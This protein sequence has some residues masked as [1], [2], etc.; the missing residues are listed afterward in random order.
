MTPAQINQRAIDQAQVVTGAYRRGLEQATGQAAP[1]GNQADNQGGN[2]RATPNTRA[3]GSDAP[4][5]RP[6][7]PVLTQND[8]SDVPKDRVDE[9]RSIVAEIA[10]TREDVNR[11][12][13][14]VGN[15]MSDSQ[16]T[17]AEGMRNILQGAAQGNRTL[18]NREATD[19]AN[20][21]RQL[22]AQN[23][24][25]ARLM[26]LAPTTEQAS[27]TASAE[28]KRKLLPAI[29]DEA[30]RLYNQ[31]STLE[32][33]VRPIGGGTERAQATSVVGQMYDILHQAHTEERP[34]TR[35]ETTRYLHFWSRLRHIGP[36]YSGWADRL[37][38]HQPVR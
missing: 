32:R 19:Y 9:L 6:L 1:T 20:L 21:Q 17:L 16:R 38:L 4:Q 28:D 33:A 15:H 5:Q 12:G 24:D 13:Q 26:S 30:A 2:Q 31:A 18:T 11:G 35:Q 10:P 23:P 27:Y 7:P 36:D 34:L 25:A 37:S 29:H 22:F 8:P 14:T 3:A